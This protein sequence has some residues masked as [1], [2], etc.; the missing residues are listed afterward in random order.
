MRK[1]L[2]LKKLKL[3]KRNKKKMGREWLAGW[4]LGEEQV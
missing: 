2:Y 1:K 3:K 4:V